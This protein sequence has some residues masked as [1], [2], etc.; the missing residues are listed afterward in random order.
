MAV[1]HGM[2][3]DGMEILTVLKGNMKH[4]KGAF[5][6]VVLLL[7]IIAMSFAA[8]TSLNDNLKKDVEAANELAGTGDYVVLIPDKQVTEDLFSKLED[9][10]NVS[11]VED[12]KG[13]AVN[14]PVISGNV[15]S[16]FMLLMP[17]EPYREQ[18]QI[19]N[20]K[21]DGFI[22]SIELSSGEILVPVSFKELYSCK[23]GDTYE[24]ESVNG[25]ETFTVKG[26]MQEPYLG[27]S[28]IGVK[29][30]FIC[31]ED[32]ERLYEL[33]ENA[34][35]DEDKMFR[36]HFIHID[37]SEDSILSLSEF[38]K[39]INDD[40]NIVE[41][42]ISL[43]REASMEYT[44]MFTTIFSG[45]LY[46]FMILLFLIVMI[47][48][49]HNI[50]TSLEMDYVDL[51]ILK[52]QGF[53][54]GKIRL[55]YVL[56]YT[57]A[58][59]FGMTLGFIFSYPVLAMLGKSMQ[60]ITGILASN[61]ISWVKCGM[62]L[63][64]LLLLL[65]VFVFVKTRKIA[66]I[67][68]VR[69]IS[70]G[71]ESIY[72][73]SRIKM[74]I[75]KNGLSGWLAFRQFTSA[76]RQYVGTILIVAILVFFMMAV[77][78]LSTGV[79]TK[80]MI[81]SFGGVV[82]DITLEATTYF[83]TEDIKKIEQ[84][85]EKKSNITCSIYLSSDY[86][87]VDSTSYHVTI[88]D[89]PE[90]MKS[91]ISGRAPLYDNEIVVTEI[92]AEM[93]DKKIGDTVKVGYQGAEEEYL[94]VGTYQSTMDV[95]K[96]FAMSLQGARRLKKDFYTTFSYV[97]LENPECNEEVVALLNETFGDIVIAEKSEESDYLDSAI[98]V[99][100]NAVTALIYIISMIFALVVVKMVCGKT[101]LKEKC[102]IG[103]YKAL[104]FTTRNLRLQFAVRFLIV[105][106]IGSALGVCSSVCVN[107]K[108]L[109]LLLRMMGITRF[110]TEFSLVTL[111]GPSL[112]I[113]IC[114]F[115]FAFLA[116]RK[117]K[118]VEVRELIV[119]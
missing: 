119:E 97:S 49:G 11:Q 109:S 7:F 28:V 68:P 87:A 94:I 29:Q 108:M 57:V 34:K 53:T 83:D 64:C 41:Y 19:F 78:I 117:V 6:S 21:A 86:F 105:A 75:R 71:K 90:E 30:V 81:E 82:A 116:A 60:S 69:A 44:L 80:S 88:Y 91:I 85:I 20:D 3:G 17:Y 72:F 56:Q 114:F 74:P 48:V 38:Q 61:H 70:G 95:G 107:D 14:E 66:K 10:E 73:D 58:G 112:L 33:Q 13:L 63:G 98:G 115:V 4:H 47:V 12:R 110:Q 40:T 23:K 25:K 35:S 16:N 65:I 99:A 100:L 93:L 118:K 9:N 89:K 42:S 26:F 76:K 5:I 24:V 101:F 27:A 67:T 104:G 84:E 102:D 111:L 55:V 103:I 43:T 46:V 2:V 96:C 36:Y 32:Y 79:T 106:V 92:L 22:D 59:F 50:S 113:C 52:A 77:T 45:I 37:Q 1:L 62:V 31:E 54:K 39:N 15:S 51:G 8:I 18:Y